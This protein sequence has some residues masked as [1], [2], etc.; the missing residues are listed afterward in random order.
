M[1]CLQIFLTTGGDY[2]KKLAFYL[3]AYFAIATILVGGHIWIGFKEEMAVAKELNR[4]QA[5]LHKVYQES[6]ALI[7]K[8]AKN[9]SN[10]YLKDNKVISGVLLGLGFSEAREKFAKLAIQSPVQSEVADYVHRVILKKKN[11]FASSLPSKSEYLKAWAFM[12]HDSSEESSK[13]ANALSYK[14]FQKVRKHLQERDQV[15]RKLMRKTRLTSSEA[16][17]AYLNSYPRSSMEDQLYHYLYK[18]N[19]FSDIDRHL[20]ERKAME[21]LKIFEDSIREIQT[22]GQNAV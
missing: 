19:L 2:M 20:P 7:E 9:P 13:A 22:A 18:N 11:P 12:P 1:S 17:T 10:P 14:F 5:D 4:N 8:S 3:F 6:L 16:T 15:C 21:V